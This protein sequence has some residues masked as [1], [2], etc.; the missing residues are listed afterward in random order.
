[1]PARA[2]RTDRIHEVR[3]W[4]RSQLGRHPDQTGDGDGM[5][6]ELVPTAGTR[7]EMRLYRTPLVVFDRA[8]GVGPEQIPN[9][10]MVGAR[11]RHLNP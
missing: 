3:G 2:T 1:M 10:L 11:G 8:Q 6:S 7:L 9:R 4:V 5:A